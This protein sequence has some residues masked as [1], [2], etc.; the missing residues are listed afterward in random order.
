MNRTLRTIV[1]V[2]GV[3]VVLLLVAPFL[4]PV[5]KFRPTIEEKASAAIGRQ[6]TLGQLSLSLLSGSLS[7]ENLAVGDDPKFSKSPFLTAKSVKVGVEMMPLI[8]SKTVNVTGITID[9]PEV[10]LLRNPAGVW[11]YSSLG[12]A[13]AK[14]QQA[15]KPSGAS[16]EVSVKK[17]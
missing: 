15:A 3:L 8:F 1:I 4:I 14:S 16:P 17:F 10:T 5:D 13:A 11:N 2:V 9:T 6:V 7:A 12:G